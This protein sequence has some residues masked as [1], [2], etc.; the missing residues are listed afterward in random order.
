[1]V[2][3]S[4]PIMDSEKSYYRVIV[5]ENLVVTITS[6][7]EEIKA[8]Q[9]RAALVVNVGGEIFYGHF[10]ETAAARELFEKLNSGE[11]TLELSDYGGFEKTGPLPWALSAEDETL[12]ATIGDLMLY[13]GDQL[14]LF[15]G[16]NTWDYTP[17]AKI[18][19]SSPDEFKA[20]LGAGSVSLTLFLEWSE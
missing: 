13:H 2:T 8:I 6:I 9:P 20:R 11:I 12:T 17:L 1:M 4:S 7:D 14:S 19:V 16:E 5:D 18:Y 3:Q 15:Y 10:A